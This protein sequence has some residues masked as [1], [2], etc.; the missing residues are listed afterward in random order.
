MNEDAWR[1][2]RASRKA[3]TRKKTYYDSEE[4][5][6][7]EAQQEF[8]GSLADR[9]FEFIQLESPKGGLAYMKRSKYLNDPN[10]VDLPQFITARGSED[11]INI[12]NTNLDGGEFVKQLPVGEFDKVYEID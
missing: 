1:K 10:Y 2:F 4:D 12:F 3:V 5:K 8:I 9:G 11:G 7:L 6:K